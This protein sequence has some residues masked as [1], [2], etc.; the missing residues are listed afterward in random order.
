[1][2]QTPS[3]YKL[4]AT[5]LELIC[6]VVV[7]VVIVGRGENKLGAEYLKIVSSQGDFPCFPF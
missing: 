2:N 1:L 4:E 6:Q 3:S 7:L 5:L